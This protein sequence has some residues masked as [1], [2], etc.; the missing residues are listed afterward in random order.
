MR[1]QII[2]GWT[3][4]R[5]AR[6]WAGVLCIALLWS[7][8][9]HAADRGALFKVTDQGRT[10]YLFGTMH[11]GQPDFYPFEARLLAAVAAAPTLALEIDPNAAPEVAAR[12]MQKHGF[13]PAGTV[14][15]PALAPR[16][17]RALQQAG[18]DPAAVAPFKPWLL[19]TVLTISEFRRL[20]YDN[21]LA[22][23]G[24]LAALAREKRVKVIELESIDAQLS[25]LDSMP[26]A[27]QW[28]F[29]QETLDDI[30]SGKHREE[31]QQVAQ[32]WATADRAALDAIAARLDADTS[33]SARFMKEVLLDGRNGALTDGIVSLMKRENNSVAAIGVLHLV[34]KRSV[35]A[36]MRQRGLTV[37]QIY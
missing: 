37:E 19:A 23:D 30:D 1:G 13:A 29:L 6:R 9:G 27:A 24:Q 16:L 5:A 33:V 14:T 2:V 8:S 34:G 26:V 31:A 25:L 35:P 3:G 10:L 17:A 28:A 18:V 20:G 11:V 32:A 15:P 7:T 22:V 21:A 4:L 12:A 36:L